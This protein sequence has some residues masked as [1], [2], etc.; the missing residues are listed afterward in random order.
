MDEGGRR[1]RLRDILIGGML[2]AFAALAAVHRRRAA[3][4]SLT[5]GLAAFEDAPCY[6]EAVAADPEARSRDLISEPPARTKHG[7]Q[8]RVRVADGD[9]L[10]RQLCAAGEEGCRPRRARRLGR[11][12]DQE[13]SEDL[14][15]ERG[16]RLRQ[17]QRR[18]QAA[19]RVPGVARI[20]HP[21]AAAKQFRGCLERL[22]GEACVCPRYD[23]LRQRPATPPRLEEERVM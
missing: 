10:A 3:A 1:Y 2:G 15:F 14:R 16:L 8:I 9:R 19:R 11:P 7:Q 20:E 18:T 4:P 17:T 12:D 5:V 13:G 21:D 23:A 6:R 22:Q